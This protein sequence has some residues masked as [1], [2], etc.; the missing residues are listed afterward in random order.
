MN[1]N[2]RSDAA[3]VLATIG[4][5][6]GWVLTFGIITV[7]A[8]MLALTWPGRTVVVVAVLFGLQLVWAGMFR[9][10]A[11]FAEDVGDGATRVLSA[12]LGVL[13]FLFGLYALRHVLVTVAALAVLLGIFWIVSGAIETFTAL[14]QREMVGRGWS[15]FTG[16]LSAVAGII[17]LAYPGISLATLAIV[18]GA[19]LLVYGVMEIVAAFQLRAAG[20]TMARLSPSAA[21]TR[22]AGA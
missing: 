11:A 3:D 5:H 18:L 15:V 7:I 1:G 2:A 6:W 13:S 9:F 12:L 19:W 16:L 14:S 21:R 20:H 8:G 4:R 17:V 22:P 10:V